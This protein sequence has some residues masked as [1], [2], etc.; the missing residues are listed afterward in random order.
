MAWHAG[1]S[2]S[3]IDWSSIEEVA[4]HVSKVTLTGMQHLWKQHATSMDTQG[5]AFAQ[6]V[7]SLHSQAMKVKVSDLFQIHF[8]NHH[9][10]HMVMLIWLCSYGYA[11][12]VM[13]MQNPSGCCFYEDIR[14]EASSCSPKQFHSW[15]QRDSSG[16]IS[17]SEPHLQATPHHKPCH[18]PFC[19]QTNNIS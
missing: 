3:T 1:P 18:I 11:H 17:T 13:L 2:D 14:A 15:H 4:S 10:A 6:R 19:S 16:N 7:Y 8:H 5:K 9:R 12:V